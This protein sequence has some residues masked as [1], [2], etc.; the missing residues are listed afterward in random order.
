[1]KDHS[2]LS[3]RIAKGGHFLQQNRA[4]ARRLFL[5]GNAHSIPEHEYAIFAV[6]EGEADKGQIRRQTR[7]GDLVQARAYFLHQVAGFQQYAKPAAV[8]NAIDPDRGG[9]TLALAQDRSVSARLKVSGPWRKKSSCPTCQRSFYIP[10]RPRP[11]QA[12][13]GNE[14]FHDLRGRCA[15]V[16]FIP[17]APR[18]A[19]QKEQPW[20]VATGN[21]EGV[22]NRELPKLEGIGSTHFQSKN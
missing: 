19:V 10:S 14:V 16:E 18:S 12:I 13:P 20:Y 11:G 5:L 3:A 22:S 4:R 8:Q 15:A 7:N 1:V 21:D 9:M 6:N 2:R 17:N